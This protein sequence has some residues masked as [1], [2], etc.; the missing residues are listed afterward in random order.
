MFLLLVTK[1]NISVRIV[2]N[3]KHPAISGQGVL[4]V[5]FETRKLGFR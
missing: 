2:N 4:Q 3:K 1:N 5:K